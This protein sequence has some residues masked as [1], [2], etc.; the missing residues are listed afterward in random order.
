MKKALIVEDHL[1]IVELIHECLRYEGIATSIVHDG[2]SAIKKIKEE[3][4]D[5][6]ILDVMLPHVNGL[7]ICKIFREHDDL[8][9]ILILSALDEVEDKVKGLEAGANDYMTKPFSTVE[10]RARIKNMLRMKQQLRYGDLIIDISERTLQENE[11]SVC[12]CRKEFELLLYMLNR[13]GSVISR[14]EILD[15][16]WSIEYFPYP[17][18]IDVHVRR[19]RKKLS[20][21]FGRKFIKT[22]HGTGYIMDI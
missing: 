5:L 20:K 12:F 1:P 19:I 16:I 11:V 3:K 2:N 8:T 22:V 6:I 17:N 7:E 15:N 10:L 21:T 14:D 18:T 13:K 9:K 4:F